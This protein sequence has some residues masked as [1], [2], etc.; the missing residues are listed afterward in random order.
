MEEILILGAN[1]TNTPRSLSL[2]R[3]SKGVLLLL[4]L[5]LLSALSK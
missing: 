3:L 5:L 1:A 2:L 4:L